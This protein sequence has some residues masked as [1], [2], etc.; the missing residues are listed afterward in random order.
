MRQGKEAA[1]QR[2][3]DDVE[4]A[5]E[6]MRAEPNRDAVT[7]AMRSEAL[8]P[9]RDAI[10]ARASCTSLCINMGSAFTAAVHMH[11]SL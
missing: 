1:A 11:S 4:A 6:R 2:I 10:K 8:E 9:T 3:M 5:V 7:A